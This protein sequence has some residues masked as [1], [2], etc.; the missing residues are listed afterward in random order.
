MTSIDETKSRVDVHAPSDDREHNAH[1]IRTASLEIEGVMTDFIV[2]PFSDRIFVIAT[3][4]QKLGTLVS[5]I[6]LWIIEFKG[7]KEQMLCSL[8]QPYCLASS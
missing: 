2:Q 3:Q 8:S 1:K 7:N 6:F 5:S 4:L